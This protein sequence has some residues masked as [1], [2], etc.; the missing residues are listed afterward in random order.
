MKC[1][2][3]ECDSASLLQSLALKDRSKIHEWATDD[4]IEKLL[5]LTKSKH[6]GIMKI[7]ADAQA[8]LYATENP[9]VIDKALEFNA[10]QINCELLQHKFLT[11][12]SRKT[13]LWGLSN[14]AAGTER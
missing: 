10:L 7:A 5:L 14:I 1:E 6:A 12:E 2:G 11:N 4:V 3:G 8:Y 9:I 13:I